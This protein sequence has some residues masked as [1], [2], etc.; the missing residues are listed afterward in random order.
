[1]SAVVAGGDGAALKRAVHRRLLVEGSEAVADR[2]TLRA[3]LAALLREE[4]PLL[5]H[6]RAEHLVDELV[7]E[8]DG[9]GPLE[10]VLG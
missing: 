3:R 6:G 8:V 10:A 2:T 7:R 5:A 9:L 4:A 1:M